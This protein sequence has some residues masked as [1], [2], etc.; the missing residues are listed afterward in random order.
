MRAVSSDE[1][2]GDPL[3]PEWQQ[4]RLRRDQPP[5]LTIEDVLGVSECQHYSV[6]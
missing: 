5:S 3:A 2:S 4:P 1:G 6:T